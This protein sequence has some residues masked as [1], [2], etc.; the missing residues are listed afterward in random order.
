MPEFKDYVS[1]YCNEDEN[2]TLRLYKLGPCCTYRG[3]RD[4]SLESVKDYLNSSWLQNLKENAKDK[5]I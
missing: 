5:E 1:T 4:E 2:S 3:T